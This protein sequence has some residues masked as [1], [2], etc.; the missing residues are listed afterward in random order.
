METHRTEFGRAHE[1]YET[2]EAKV[3]C[4]SQFFEDYGL[5]RPASLANETQG[6]GLLAVERDAGESIKRKKNEEKEAV[7]AS[8]LDEA[9]GRR[10]EAETKN[11]EVKWCQEMR[12]INFNEGVR[13]TTIM[14]G[15]VLYRYEEVKAREGGGGAVAAGLGWFSGADVNPRRLGFVREDGVDQGGNRFVLPDGTRFERKG[16]VATRSVEALESTASDLSGFRPND[17]SGLLYFGGEKQLC[18]SDRSAFR[19]TEG[20]SIQEEIRLRLRE[21]KSNDPKS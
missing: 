5:K 21:R 4:A 18:V 17:R 11:H 19:P 1:M 15:V 6:I 20:M 13:R 14:E 3:D 10:I 8:R 9:K 16:F 7:K 2:R 12:A